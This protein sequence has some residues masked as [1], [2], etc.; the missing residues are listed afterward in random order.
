MYICIVCILASYS[1]IRQSWDIKTRC[2]KCR[3][4]HALQ[5]Q[6]GNIAQTKKLWKNLRFSLQARKNQGRE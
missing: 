6:K 2:P 4:F 1:D 3:P 5:V